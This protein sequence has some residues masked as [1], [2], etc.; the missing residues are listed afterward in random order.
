MDYKEALFYEKLNGREVKCLLCPQ[1]CRIVEG[2]TGF[3][4]VRKNIDGKLYSLIYGQISSIALDPIEKKPLYHYHPK[5]FIL[6]IGTKGCNLACGFC[7]NFSISQGLNVPTQEI[8]CEEIITKAKNCQSF[9]IAYTYNEPLIWYEFVLDT[10]KLARREGLKNVLVTNGFINPEPL[11]K[12]LPF[13]DAMN[14]DLKSIEDDFY[15]NTCKGF[16]AAVLETIKKAKQFCHVELTNLII[17]T[18]ND[19]EGNFEKL[20]D[21]IYN[22]LGEDTPLHFSRYFPCHKFDIPP[23]PPVTLQKARDIAAAK[24]KYVYLG[25]V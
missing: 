9:G 19:S 4:R 21:W 20:V 11:R 6:S 12:I 17:P 22:N 18:L 25:N 7:Q 14:I 10:A 15:R 1:T 13:I 2:K 5:E 3:C 24:L 8:T 23:T 16:L